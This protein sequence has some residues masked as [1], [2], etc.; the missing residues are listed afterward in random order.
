MARRYPPGPKGQFL[1]GSMRQLQTNRLAFMMTC[2]DTYGDIVH[3]RIGPQHLYLLNHPDYIHQILVKQADKFHKLPMLKKAAERALGQGLLTSDGYL[4]KRQRKLMQPAFHHQ[5]I[6]AY[7]ETMTT[8][9]LRK[10]EAWRSGAQCDIN[11]EMMELTMQ[12]IGKTL[13]DAEI[14]R[15]AEL[16]RAITVGIETVGQRATQPFHLPD[17][18]PTPKNRKRVAAA[19]LLEDNI[20]NI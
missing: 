13:F 2:R 1:I 16:G 7:A 5:R 19:R 4:H 6:A 12:I 14:T 9:T 20:M 17:W 15:E 10:L 3:F 18:V 8:Y 11:H